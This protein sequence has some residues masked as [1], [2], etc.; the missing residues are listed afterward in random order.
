MHHNTYCMYAE[1]HCNGGTTAILAIFTA[2]RYS[3]AVCSSCMSVRLSFC[4]SHA[5]IVSK[6]LNG[7]SC[8]WRRSFLS[9]FTYP[10][11]CYKDSGISKIRYFHLELFQSLEFKKIATASRSCCQQNSSTVELVDR[12]CDGRRV[13]AARTF[14]T[15]PSTVMF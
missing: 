15:Q 13:V 10:T 11:L 9:R 2:R 8:F 7:S 1:F 3:S 6:R 14:T 4:L 5:G 12:T